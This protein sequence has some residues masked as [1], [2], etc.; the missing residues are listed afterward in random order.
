[1]QLP[2]SFTVSLQE[3]YSKLYTSSSFAYTPLWTDIYRQE[4]CW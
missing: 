1:M 2:P 3:E 4:H